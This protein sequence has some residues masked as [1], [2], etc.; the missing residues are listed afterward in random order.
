MVKKTSA[1]NNPLLNQVVPL[2]FDE[3]DKN[4]LLELTADQK[5]DRFMSQWM[6]LMH[7]LTAYKNYFQRAERGRERVL[8]E[9]KMFYK[10]LVVN[11]GWSEQ[12]FVLV[13]DHLLKNNSMLSE[14][15]FANAEKLHSEERLSLQLTAKRLE[16]RQ[17]RRL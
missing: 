14:K 10:K 12:K 4:D 16:R 13:V 15:T 17:G 11:G 2:E 8:H 5:T 6:R 9:V 7:P 1:K 3:L